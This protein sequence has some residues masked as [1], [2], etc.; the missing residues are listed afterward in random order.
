[1]G[2]PNHALSPCFSFCSGHQEARVSVKFLFLPS[3]TFV[4]EMIFA[5]LNTCS[6]PTFLALELRH[7]KQVLCH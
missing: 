7:A 6:T 5:V 2:G 4:Q 1:M 3:W